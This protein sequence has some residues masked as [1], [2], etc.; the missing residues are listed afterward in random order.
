MKKFGFKV[1]LAGMLLSLSLLGGSVLSGPGNTFV[2]RTARGSYEETVSALK[3]AISENGM[4]VAGEIDQKQILSMAGLN[5]EGSHTFFVGNPM[6][7]K[8]F[9]KMN[10]AAGT[11]LPVR[12]FVWVNQDGKTEVGYFKISAQL[13]FID[14]RLKEP[15][16]MLDQKFSM[17]LDSATR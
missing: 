11:V 13:G 15:G 5:L 4:M 7:G 8:K 2:H 3:H 1:M 6:V 14:S 9:F 12:V 17:I 10:P 16:K